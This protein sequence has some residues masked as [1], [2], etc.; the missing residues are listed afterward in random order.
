MF[1]ILSLIVVTL[2][3]ATILTFL[4][5]SRARW[6]ALAGSILFLA[7]VAY[8]LLTFAPWA[9]FGSGGVPQYNDA[10]TYS[11]ISISWLHVNYAVGID[12]ISLILIVLT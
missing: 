9:G 10:E 12:G 2:L 5:G 4:S 1:P 3:G 7:E 8:L 11:W 6:V